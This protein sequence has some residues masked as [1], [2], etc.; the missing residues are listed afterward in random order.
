MRVFRAGEWS[1]CGRAGFRGV[2]MEY[3]HLN[4]VLGRRCPG[5]IIYYGAGPCPVLGVDCILISEKALA[6]RLFACQ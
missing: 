6:L 5:G 1:S 4:R 3:L 2:E